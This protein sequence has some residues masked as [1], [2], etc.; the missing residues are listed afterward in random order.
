MQ[1]GWDL[2]ASCRAPE[3]HPGACFGF[4]C[5]CL[6]R[7]AASLQQGHLDPVSALDMGPRLRR[8]AFPS[9]AFGYK[10][11]VCF[12]ACASEH[13]QFSHA[14]EHGAWPIARTVAGFG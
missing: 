6:L 12:C 4:S 8:A 11:H 10:V 7:C 9:F 1:V 3:V 2:L 5:C 14:V 13:T